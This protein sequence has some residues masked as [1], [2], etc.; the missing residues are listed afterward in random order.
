MPKTF[1]RGGPASA[2]PQGSAADVLHNEIVELGNKD[3]IIEPGIT[4]DELTRIRA[5]TLQWLTECVRD[6]SCY[7][8][9]RP[10]ALSNYRIL[11]RDGQ[12]GCL[13][14]VK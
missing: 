10:I 4:L 12:G 8:H 14:E 11:A 3:V 1:Y 2:M 5:A 13:V 7:G 9:T 6:A